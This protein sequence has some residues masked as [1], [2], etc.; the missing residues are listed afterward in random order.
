M[1]IVFE[2]GTDI[3][4]ARQLVNERLIQAGEDRSPRGSAPEMGPISTGLGKIYM[5]DGQGREASAKRR[6]R[7]ADGAADH[8]GLGRRPP[9]LSVPGVIE[10]NTIGGYQKQ[11][12]VLPDP[13]RLMASDGLPRG[14]GRAGRKQRA[15]SARATSSGTASSIWSARRA[16][17]RTRPR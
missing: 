12:H 2:E 15:M 13:A 6:S 8:P 7:N 4:W 1:T 9:L 5:F 14:D 11:Y 17:S 10:V 16:K 3:Y